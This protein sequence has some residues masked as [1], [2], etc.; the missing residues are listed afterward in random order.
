MPV[1]QNGKNYY[2]A[3][4]VGAW[5]ALCWFTLGYM[6]PASVVAFALWHAYDF[7]YWNGLSPLSHLIW[8]PVQ[9]GVCLALLLIVMWCKRGRQWSRP[10]VM[11]SG[12]V[13]AMLLTLT[14]HPASG[15]LSYYSE[16]A[17]IPITYAAVIAL[18]WTGASKQSDAP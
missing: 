3:R 9:Y 6:V 11:L 14:T 7:W 17:S 15:F 2:T 13:G 4:G 5:G 10:R 8:I 1:S 16:A 12:S 18:A